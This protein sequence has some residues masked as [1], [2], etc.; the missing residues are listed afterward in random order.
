MRSELFFAVSTIGL[1]A[2]AAQP[3]HARTSPPVFIARGAPVEPP[4]GFVAM[5]G[6]DKSFCGTRGHGDAADETGVP[7]AFALMPTAGLSAKP[8][9]PTQQARS[10]A[11]APVE[12]LKS[13]DSRRKAALLKEVN[14]LVNSRVRQRPD[15]EIYAE[16]ER[17]T[18]SGIGPQA[19]GDCEDLA[20]EKRYQL[21]VRGFDPADVSFAV[22]FSAATGLHTVLVARTD[23]GDMVLDSSTPWVRRADRTDYSWISIQST[24][25]QMTWVSARV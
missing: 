16:A 13:T 7:T 23:E 9:W 5:C 22:V 12:R 2:L 20:I 14:N 18:R 19:V 17:W 24:G 6:T 8:L 25:D 10:E 4:R 1:V 3:V 15:M 21:L 11:A